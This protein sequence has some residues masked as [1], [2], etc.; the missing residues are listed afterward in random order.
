MVNNVICLLDLKEEYLGINVVWLWYSYNI[1]V[2]KV[3]VDW[4]SEVKS[5]NFVDLV[6]DGFIKYFI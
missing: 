4:Y 1:V 2:E 3:I 5:Y 6:I